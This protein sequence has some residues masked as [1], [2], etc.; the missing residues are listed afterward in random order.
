M[1]HVYT[2]PSY[3]RRCRQ[4]PCELA[5]IGCCMYVMIEWHVHSQVEVAAGF[6]IS[7]KRLTRVER[8]PSRSAA[9]V[10]C[11]LRCRVVGNSR[12]GAAPP[13]VSRVGTTGPSIHRSL[14]TPPSAH[15][16][17]PPSPAAGA[18]QLIIPGCRNTRWRRMRCH[19]DVYGLNAGLPTDTARLTQTR[20]PLP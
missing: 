10:T 12:H 4:F 8:L 9:I 6:S 2:I 19:M 7:S 14:I 15:P 3:G 18:D 16:P 1:A 20:L 17:Q 11:L 13:S 5:S